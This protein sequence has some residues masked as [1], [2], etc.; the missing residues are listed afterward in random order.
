MQV[1]GMVNEV[2]VFARACI[3]KSCVDSGAHESGC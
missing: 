3:V 1:A 2:L